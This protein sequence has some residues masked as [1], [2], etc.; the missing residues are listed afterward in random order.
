MLL[1]NYIQ[2]LTE[3]N[4]FWV[5]VSL[6]AVITVCLLILLIWQQFTKRTE[7]EPG[8]ATCPHCRSKKTERINTDIADHVCYSCGNMW[9][10]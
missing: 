2:S 6:F 1:T 9:R 4:W 3:M 8:N 5:I 10:E 7:P